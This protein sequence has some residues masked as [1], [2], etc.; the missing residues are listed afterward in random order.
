M[1]KISG[2]ILIFCC[3]C[4]MSPDYLCGC[5]M[6]VCAQREDDFAG[7]SSERTGVASVH[8]GQGGKASASPE[9]R[10]QLL[11]RLGDRLR[12]QVGVAVGAVFA[13]SVGYAKFK[14]LVS[15][16]DGLCASARRHTVLLYVA[17][18]VVAKRNICN[19]HQINSWSSLYHR[20]LIRWSTETRVM[21][22]DR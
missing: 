5:G 11:L 13:N 15:S 18:S 19:R 10:H 7:E 22:M 3:G 6:S 21:Q 4:G 20:N 2:V 8:S 12:F 16:C 17:G 1:L 9:V 14:S